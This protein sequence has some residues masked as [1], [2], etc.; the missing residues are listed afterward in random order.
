MTRAQKL[1]RDAVRLGDKVCLQIPED[2]PECKWPTRTMAEAILIPQL[3]ITLNLTRDGLQAELPG[4]NGSRRV[5][6]LR[7]ADFYESCLRMLKAQAESKIQIGLDGAP[8]QAQVKHWER[9]QIWSD[10][11]CPFCISEGR[12]SRGK[13]RAARYENTAG[14]GSVTV[15]RIPSRRARRAAGLRITGKT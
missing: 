12:V 9:H 3:I 4:A 11:R 2:L 10:D 5:I 15:T 14:D 8:T 13:A 6:A 7:G 1:R